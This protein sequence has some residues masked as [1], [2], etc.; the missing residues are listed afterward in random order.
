MSAKQYP[1]IDVAVH[2]RVRLPFARGEAVVLFSR[3][4]ARVLWANGR[5]AALFGHDNIYDFLDAGPDRADVAFRQLVA[6]A[7]Q[8]E[9][10]GARRSF[11]MRIGSGFR[12]VPVNAAV[13]AVTIRPGD[14]AILFSAP[15]TPL[16]R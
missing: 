5:G 2:E 15:T 7:R 12:S 13:E 1:F 16:G 10:P 14:E 4:M 11:L 8:V 3:N 9:T 6:T